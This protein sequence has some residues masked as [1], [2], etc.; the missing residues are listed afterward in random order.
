MNCALRAAIGILLAHVLIVCDA[1][2]TEFAERATVLA[3]DDLKTEVAQE[4]SVLPA[5]SVFHDNAAAVA[6]ADRLIEGWKS[7]PVTIGW[8]RIQLGLHIKHKTMPTRGARGLALVHV[9]MHDAYTLAGSMDAEPRVAVSQS[10]A[11]VLSYLYP[12]EEKSFQRIVEQLSQQHQP[13]TGGDDA[14]SA[15]V[16]RRLG[17][18]VANHLIARAQAD[19]AQRGWNGSR[20]Q[21]YGEGRAYGPGTWEPTPPYF[22]YP[23]DEPFAPGWRTWTLKR[24]DQFRAPPPPAWGSP[25]YLDA[26]RELVAINRSLSDEQLRIAKFWVDGHGSVTPP[27]H[28]NQIAIDEVVRSRLGDAETARLFAVMNVAMADAFIAAWETKYH[29]WSA[30]PITAAKRLLNVNLK[31][32]TLTPPFPSYVSGHAAF[33]GAAATVLGEYFPDQRSR[34]SVMA[35]EAATSRLYGGIH[36]RF[37]NEEGLKMGRAIGQHVMLELPRD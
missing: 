25:A 16:S 8:T 34:F 24:N 3:H 12:A 20:L 33:S 10:A 2:T 35:E 14:R 11:D 21:W 17:R 26:L 36:F 28:W 1:A 13:G 19:G 29:Y 32:P 30:R 22:Y 5:M 27:G 37:D 15:S 18:V 7:E 4:Q 6:D 31:P 9:A 23:P